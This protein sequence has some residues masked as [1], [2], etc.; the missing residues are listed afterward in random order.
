IPGRHPRPLLRVAD[1]ASHLPLL[2]AY[3][4]LGVVTNLVKMLMNDE[5]DGLEVRHTVCE[6][7]RPL[8]SYGLCEDSNFTVIRLLTRT[9]LHHHTY[10]QLVLP[11]FYVL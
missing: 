4:E 6:K 3:E 2:C 1:V 9:D 5:L 11:Q 10:C 7:I 8:P